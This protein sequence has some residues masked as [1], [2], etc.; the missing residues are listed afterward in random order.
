MSPSVTTRPTL[1]PSGQISTFSLWYKET[2]SETCDDIVATFA[3]F[4]KTGF[5]GWN[6]NLGTDWW[7]LVAGLLVLH[8]HRRTSGD[9]LERPAVAKMGRRT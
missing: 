1:V 3:A 4:F 5:Y 7:K 2:G 6:T 8:R 9:H